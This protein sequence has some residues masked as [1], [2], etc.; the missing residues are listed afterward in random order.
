MSGSA[1]R[2]TRFDTWQDRF[3]V[4]IV[5]LPA[6]CVGAFLVAVTVTMVVNTVRMERWA[7]RFY[8]ISAPGGDEILESGS[9][10]GLLEGNGNHCDRRAWI[11]LRTDLDPSAVESHYDH[12]L[13]SASQ[14]EGSPTGRDD[15][16]TA[17]RLD[18]DRVRVQRFEFGGAAGLDLR[19]H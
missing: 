3:V 1:S 6:A 14:S 2:G 17:T 7:D 8:E 16:V 13:D 19:C 4:A 9:E 11:V 12:P 10:Y 15:F 18:A 5:V